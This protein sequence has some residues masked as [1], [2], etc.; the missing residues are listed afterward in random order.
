MAG[1]P[2]WYSKIWTLAIQDTS[3]FESTLQQVDFIEQ[4]LGL[5]RDERVLDLACGTGRHALE[6][7]RRGYAVVGVDIT[8]AYIDAACQQA[9]E[10]G[11]DVEFLRA[12]IRDLSFYQAFDVVLNLAD[13]AI[14]YLETDAENLKLFDR[15]AAALKPGGKH[16][17]EVCNAEY[18]A[19]H[20]PR[21][22]WEVGQNAVSL[23]DFD[24]DRQTRRMRYLAYTLK[25]G[26]VL[27]LP[28]GT[29]SSIR[30]YSLE[31]LQ[32]ILEARGLTIQG[33]YGDYDLAT[34]ASEG[35]L[36]LIVYSVKNGWR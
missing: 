25:L 24:W 29:A 6:L 36:T 12:D 23:A 22:H 19:T 14:G 8:A 9:R 16:L 11:L 20:F 27:D 10:Y 7:A 13:G 30:L 17:M 31:E 18:A 5:H 21:R 26:E 4:A 2:Q 33:A 32:Q 3:W 1:D 35:N 34:S 15:I 28:R